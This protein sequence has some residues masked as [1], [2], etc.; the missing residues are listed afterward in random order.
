MKIN[1]YKLYEARHIIIE[2]TTENPF[3]CNSLIKAFDPVCFP[4]IVERNHFY[5][6]MYGEWKKSVTIQLLRT[7]NQTQ[8]LNTFPN[9]WMKLLFDIIIKKKKLIKNELCTRIDIWIGRKRNFWK[10]KKKRKSKMIKKNENIVI[11]KTQ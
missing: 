11:Y 3:L 7:V 5:V 8:A 6:E 10:C 1:V 4:K 9:E 2:L